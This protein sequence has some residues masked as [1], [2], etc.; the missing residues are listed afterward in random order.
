MGY[1]EKVLQPGEVILSRTHLHWFI[2]LSSITTLILALVVLATGMI[3]APDYAYY[4]EIV[5]GL[6][7][8]FGLLKLFVAWIKRSSTELAVT[9]RRIIHKTGFLSRTTSEMNR[10]KVESVDVQ[11]SLTGRIFG[12]GT[13]LV[14]GVG[15]TWE[16]FAHIAN[17]L[18]FRSSITAA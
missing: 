3:F 4:V 12:Y 9:N 1:V 17:P 7:G 14:R 11:Q 13:V 5:A 15:S 16:P 6:L 18:A 2:Y 8:I 10:E